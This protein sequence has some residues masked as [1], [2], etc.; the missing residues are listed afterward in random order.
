[1]SGLAIYL[2]GSPRIERDGSMIEVDTRKAIALLSYLAITGISHTRDALATL[3]Y[4]DLD[5][6]HARAAL[7]R[8]LSALNKALDNPAL[9]IR[10]ESLE[11]K[12]E[13]D[14]WVDVRTFTQLQEEIRR[15]VHRDIQTCQDCMRRLEQADALYQGDF[16]AGF[17]LRDSPNFDDWQFFQTESLRNEFAGILEQI[18]E[19]ECYQQSFEM[20]IEHARRWLSLDPLREE[21]H[22]ALM[23]CYTWSG[24]PNLALRQYRECVRILDQELGVTPLEETTQLYH[25]ILERN[26][27]AP[28]SEVGAQAAELVSM[29]PETFPATI[30]DFPFVGRTQEL[31]LI[32]WAYQWSGTKGCLF[33]IDGEAGI[34]KTRLAEEFL[35]AKQ[36]RGVKTIVGRGFEGETELAFGIFVEGLRGIYTE[37]GTPDRLKGASEI[38]LL[39]AARLIPEMRNDFPNLPDPPALTGP[40][41]QANFFEGFRRILLRLIGTNPPGI[42]FLD[43]LHWAD[44]ASLDFL[45]YLV[46]RL[47]HQPLFILGTWRNDATQTGER[48]QQIIAT[49]RRAGTGKTLS[50]NRLGQPEIQELVEGIADHLPEI[51]PDFSRQLY[52]ET[53][54]LPF[55]AVEYLNVLLS[56]RRIEAM[57]K[58]GEEQWVL[59][60]SVREVLQA[61][62]LDLGD[63]ARQLLSTAAVIGRSFDFRT[64]MLASGRSEVETL[65]GLEELLGHG[66]IKERPTVETPG[67]VEYFFNHE[68]LRQ[69]VYEQTSLTRRRLLHQRA[70]EV[71]IEQGRGLRYINAFASIIAQHYQMAGQPDLAAKFYFQAGESARALFAHHQ[72][73]ANFQAALSCGHAEAAKIHEAIGDSLGMLGEYS[74]AL[75][76]YETAISLLAPEPNP[77]LEAKLGNIHHRRGEYELAVCRFQAAEE[78]LPE[79]AELAFKA[80][81]YSDW[82][83]SAYYTGDAEEAQRLAERSL[84]LAEIDGDSLA[85]A[86]ANNTL[87]ILA[88]HHGNFGQAQAFLEHSL[89]LAERLQ[90]P[91]ASVAALNNLALL[92]ASQTDTSQAINLI[93]KALELCERIG[94]RHLEAALHNNLADFLHSSGEADEAME[95]LREAVVIFAEIGMKMEEM[96]PEIWK[97]TEW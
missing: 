3:L 42:L 30:Q 9:V 25:Q 53:E 38:W 95:Q 33:L 5:Q 1:M 17:T 19:V 65:A 91:A 60:G 59:P 84:H 73:V 4:P 35:T 70:A 21:A 58:P 55:I 68:K 41:A 6:A 85:I 54:G 37:A 89:Q 16:M 86:Q 48:L 82:S 32:S 43:D 87:G 88:R 34:G 44:T 57:P 2:L 81:L 18:V 26:L 46:Q 96:S 76:S 12:Y 80:R 64:L 27:K 22:R 77:R 79:Q 8:T 67:Q 11:L 52:Q 50:L 83:R 56:D 10:R 90:D 31:E 93:Q 36:L 49:S 7:R 14:V 75:S 23:S 45:A 24:Q 97:L 28:A 61:R 72:A 74:A 62:L 51:P 39:Q 15:H 47:E 66:V 20:A 13:G 78:D 63:I 29:P 69:L 94:D 40:G 71:L 92:F